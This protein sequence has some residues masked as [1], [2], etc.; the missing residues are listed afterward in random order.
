MIFNIR[1][2]NNV[3]DGGGGSSSVVAS[4][5]AAGARAGAGA[6]SSVNEI[7]INIDEYN[8]IVDNIETQTTEIIETQSGYVEPD[9]ACL[10]NDVIPD[11]EQADHEVEDMLRLMQQE[12]NHVISVMRGIRQ[13]YETVDSDMSQDGNNNLYGST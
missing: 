4:G 8:R 5:V 12:L 6:V 9:A 3:A 2:Y 1:K 11:Y 10:L 13:D 7:K